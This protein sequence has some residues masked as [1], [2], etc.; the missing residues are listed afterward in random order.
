M[1]HLNE[2]MQFEIGTFWKHRCRG[3]FVFISGIDHAANLVTIT[4][5]DRFNS[6]TI[7]PKQLRGIYDELEDQPALTTNELDAINQFLEY[8]AKEVEADEIP[9]RS[10]HFRAVGVKQFYNRKE[11][12]NNFGRLK[13]AW[14]TEP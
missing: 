7:T 1:E 10:K 13:D 14:S 2:T 4:D 6:S 11:N 8:R 3:V 12:R 9:P 5:T